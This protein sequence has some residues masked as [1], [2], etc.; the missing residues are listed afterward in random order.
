MEGNGFI[1]RWGGKHY[2]K[3]KILSYIPDNYDTYVEPFVGG[4]S[5]Y[6]NLEKK[7]KEIINDLDKEL[8]LYYKGLKKYDYEKIN[9]HVVGTYTKEDFIKI[10]NSKPTDNFNKFIRQYKLFKL[11]F[12]SNGDSFSKGQRDTSSNL[13]TIN[14]IPNNKFQDRLKDTIIENK[15]ADLIIKK[16]DSEGTIFYLD[17]PYEKSDMYNH[18]VIIYEDLEKTLSNLKGKFILSINKS[19]YIKKLFHNFN[20]YTMSTTYQGVDKNHDAR[21]VNEYI[22]T[23]FKKQSIGKNICYNNDMHGQ[24]L[25]DNLTLKDIEKLIKLLKKHYEVEKYK[26]GRLTTIS[27]ATK[28]RV[29]KENKNPLKSLIY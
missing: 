21:K 26:K 1:C 28:S 29:K 22:I 8:I 23:N 19:E 12:R 3:N 6:L 11:S 15:P 14:P 7:G 27:T 10:K 16:Y 20:I 17:P 5:V 2:S 4:G 25:L 13:H 18:N 24:G 9:K